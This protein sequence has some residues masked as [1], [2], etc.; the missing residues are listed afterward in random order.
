MCAAALARDKSRTSFQRVIL[1]E[2]PHKQYC[3]HC[4]NAAFI[5][6]FWKEYDLSSTDLHAEELINCAQSIHAFENINN[7]EEYF[8]DGIYSNAYTPIMQ[9]LENAKNISDVFN[10]L[11]ETEAD[12]D[13]T[14]QRTV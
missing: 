14:H 5:N 8:Y 11:I 7:R 12:F 1:S 3:I 13:K 2:N 6:G 9:M 10:G 4:F